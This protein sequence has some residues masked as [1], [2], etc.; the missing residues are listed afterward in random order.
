MNPAPVQNQGRQ[1]AARQNVLL[2]GYTVRLWPRRLQYMV[3]SPKE[4]SVVKRGRFWAV[5]LDS[6]LLAVTVYKKG[7][8]AIKRLL[9]QL[10]LNVFHCSNE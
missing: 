1:G 7:A 6:E 3:M 2:P 9:D 10:Y 4:V 5:Y 8:F